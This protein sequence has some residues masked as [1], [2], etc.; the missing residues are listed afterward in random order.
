MGAIKIYTHNRKKVKTER[1]R[2]QIG[3]NSPRIGGTVKGV[4][5]DTAITCKDLVGEKTAGPS[6]ST[7]N[8]MHGS[9]GLMT[10]FSQL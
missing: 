6:T 1:F 10:F 7:M 9:K 3:G 4:V 5:V 8:W 2:V